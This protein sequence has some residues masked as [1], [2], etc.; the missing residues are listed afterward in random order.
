MS[1]GD[2]TTLLDNR[3]NEHSCMH[4]NI[5]DQM[6]GTKDYLE[7]KKTHNLL[8]NMRRLYHFAAKHSMKIFTNRSF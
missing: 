3:E 8:D 7:I 1:V 6:N 5:Q 4:E 2:Q